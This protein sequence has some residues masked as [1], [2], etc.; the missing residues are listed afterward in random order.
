MPPIVKKCYK[1]AV[2]I[3]GWDHMEP[4]PDYKE[5]F[6]ERDDKFEGF[7]QI[8]SSDYRH[9]IDLCPSDTEEEEDPE[10]ARAAEEK[11]R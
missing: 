3:D 7:D 5:Y 4:L 1:I 9:F 11:K 6:E 8:E 10:A 2:V